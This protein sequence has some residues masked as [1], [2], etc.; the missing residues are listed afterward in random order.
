MVSTGTP[1]RS[2]S[3]PST[4]ERTTVAGVPVR[5]EVYHRLMNPEDPDVSFAYVFSGSRGCVVGAGQEDPAEAAFARGRE[6]AIFVPQS[7]NPGPTLKRVERTLASVAALL[8]GPVRLTYDERGRVKLHAR[9]ALRGKGW[10]AGFT[11]QENG[12]VRACLSL[13]DAFVTEELKT[14]PQGKAGARRW[15]VVAAARARKA[16][17]VQKRADRE[18]ARLGVEF[19]WEED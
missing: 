10:E 16:L 3:W 5:V 8:D 19:A 13:G 15:A 17:A 14:P 4:V 12:K 1:F 7:V 6:K 18:A 9:W 11:C 2:T